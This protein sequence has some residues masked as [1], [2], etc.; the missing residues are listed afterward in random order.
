METELP[1]IDQIEAELRP[2]LPATGHRRESAGALK[3]VPSCAPSP[4]V[5]G[6]YNVMP[7]AASTATCSILS[8]LS[9]S[10]RKPRQKPS[11]IRA[12]LRRHARR[13][14]PSAS[15]VI[16]SSSQAVSFSSCASCMGFAR[17]SVAGCSATIPLRTLRTYG[18]FVGSGKPASDA[19][20]R[21]LQAASAGY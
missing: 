1:T 14:R 6:R 10:E 7:R 8:R 2:D 13:S 20:A 17:F 9:S 3:V 4:F 11:S 18:A 19:I 15:L 12:R 21:A 16:C 5:R